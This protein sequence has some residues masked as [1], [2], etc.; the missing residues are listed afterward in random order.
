ML[1]KAEERAA[2]CRFF[3]FFK[4]IKRRVGIEVVVVG[5]RLLEIAFSMY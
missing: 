1:R 5:D 3:A 2:R 4:S